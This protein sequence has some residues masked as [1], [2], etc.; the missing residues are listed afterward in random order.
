[1]LSIGIDGAAQH[2]IICGRRNANIHGHLQAYL[3]ENNRGY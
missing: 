1:M 3:P 2:E